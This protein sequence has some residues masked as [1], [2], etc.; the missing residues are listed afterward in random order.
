MNTIKGIINAAIDSGELYEVL[1]ENDKYVMGDNGVCIFKPEPRLYM[2]P[3]ENLPKCDRE[4]MTAVIMECLMDKVLDCGY[5]ADRA[6]SIYIDAAIKLL[7]TPNIMD[8]FY[9]VLSYYSFEN[10]IRRMP[11][12]NFKEHANKLRKS[13]I[14]LLKANLAAFGQVHV[15]YYDN[16]TLLDI[17]KFE[18][19]RLN[20][21]SGL[22]KIIID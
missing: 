8:G 10:Y 18:D 4:T 9:G 21:E 13:V 19:D 6:M 12:N 20:K 17:I 5:D 1:R 15:K 7:L 2:M 16:A 11:V 22:A 14:K 3:E